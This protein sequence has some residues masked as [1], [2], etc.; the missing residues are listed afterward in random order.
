MAKK[1]KD[2]FDL[3]EQEW[4]DAVQGMNKEDIKKRVC[5]VALN[6]AEL[7]KAKREDQ[8]LDEKRET[9]RDASS[10]Y[11]EGTKMNKAKIEYMKM[12]LDG[13]GQ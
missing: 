1:E 8:D 13:M 9:Y 4:R 12:V 2:K 7:M 6:Q 3:L 11:R 5:E 10:I